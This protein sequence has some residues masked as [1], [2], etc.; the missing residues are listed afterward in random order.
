MH[1]PCSTSR[2]FPLASWV[3]R[4]LGVG[5]RSPA[6]PVTSMPI[7]IDVL[8]RKSFIDHS[9]VAGQYCTDLI[10]LGRTLEH[11][12]MIPSTWTKLLSIAELRPRGETEFLP[13]LPSNPTC[14][15]ADFST[16]SKE[17]SIFFDLSTPASCK[18]TMYSR[19]RRI[20]LFARSSSKDLN[21]LIFTIKRN[22]LVSIA[23]FIFE[24]NFS[25]YSSNSRKVLNFRLCC[26][27]VLLSACIIEWLDKK[28]AITKQL[29]Q[30][31]DATWTWFISEGS[32]VPTDFYTLHRALSMK[33][34]RA[35]RKATVTFC[36]EFSKD[37]CYLWQIT[38]NFWN[39]HL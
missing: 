18:A 2:G 4:A 28:E 25:W 20:I 32:S 12:V 23:S 9:F 19:G 21:S 29:S 14:K 13:K 1:R 35:V 38:I 11:F 15:S 26:S 22:F 39:C 34:N 8:S 6:P 10:S 7:S 5:R 16:F 27:T 31:V 30:S 33:L 17:G 3:G 24:S 36:F 37:N